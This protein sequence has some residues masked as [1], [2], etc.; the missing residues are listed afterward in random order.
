MSRFVERANLPHRADTVLLGEKYRTLLDEPLRARGIETIYV[1]DNP[2]VDRRLAGHADLSVLHAGGER[3]Y[4]A[5]YLRESELHHKLLGFGMDVRFPQIEQKPDYPGDVSLNVCIA[6]SYVL[7]NERYVPKEIDEYFTINKCLT[8]IHCRQGYARCCVC[9]VREGS[10]ITSD[11]GIAVAA[12]R[13]G[14]E[15]LLISAGFFG[16]NGYPY[17]FIGGSSFKISRGEQ[18]FTGTLTGHNDENRILSFLEKHG[19]RP[20]FLTE[21]PAFDIGSGIPITEK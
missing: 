19:V 15:V 9:P 2:N 20:V 13:A 3:I 16:L 21:R 6:G 10:I 8:S 17:G 1:P 18:A 5:P 4:L 12:E 11:A 14:L 7:R